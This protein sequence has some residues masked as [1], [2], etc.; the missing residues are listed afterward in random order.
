M[1]TLF[2]EMFTLFLPLPLSFSLSGVIRRSAAKTI[3]SGKFFRPPRS[4]A[5]FSVFSP[6]VSAVFRVSACPN[7][8]LTF[9]IF[10][11]G[12]MMWQNFTPQK[13]KFLSEEKRSLIESQDFIFWVFG[14]ST[15]AFYRSSLYRQSTPLHRHLHMVPN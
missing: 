5:Q 1:F 10:L 2:S 7:T 15:F 9:Q 12:E 11:A 14:G 6:L 13:R 4:D 3:S 8:F